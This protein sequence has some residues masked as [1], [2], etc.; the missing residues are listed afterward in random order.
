METLI[1]DL[2]GTLTDPA[3]GI[4]RSLSYALESLGYRRLTAAEVSPLVGPPLDWAFRQIV[5]DASDETVLTLVAK[6]RERY[7]AVGYA[8]N[9]L[10]AGIAEALRQLSGDRIPMGVCTSKRT[11][12]AEQILDMFGLRR[13]FGFVCGADVGVTKCD[14]LQSL[15]EQR[16]ITETS[17][18]VGDRALDV[19]AAR[20]NGLGAVGV[21]WG[22]GSAAELAAAAPDR[23]LSRT[24][25]LAAFD[26]KVR[27]D[28][29]AELT[30]RAR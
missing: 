5:R 6:Y 23:T 14:Q 12:V 24:A 19:E 17:V 18:M 20:A 27:V 28:A 2:D 15:L 7:R 26:R 3:V 8:E 11:D 4:R 30:N 16:A 1:F 10:Y 25:E 9:V 22:Y 29:Q 13:H 21:L